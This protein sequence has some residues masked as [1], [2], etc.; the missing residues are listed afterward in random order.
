MEIQ[1]AVFSIGALKFPGPDGF[2]AL[3]YHKYWRIIGRD[4]ITAIRSFFEGKPKM[5]FKSWDSIRAPRDCRGLSI[6]KMYD[7]NKVLLAKQTW[8]IHSLRAKPHISLLK[9]KYLK[10][11]PLHSHI[12]PSRCSYFWRDQ[13]YFVLGAFSLD[14]H[15]PTVG[16]VEAA[17]C[18]IR[19][20]QSLHINSL[21]LRGD[22]KEVIDCL[23]SPFHTLPP[24][25]KALFE[26]L[27]ADLSFFTS[28]TAVYINRAENFIAHKLAQWASFCNL[29]GQSSS[30]QS[31]LQYLIEKKRCR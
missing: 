19:C 27:A 2:S 6:R 10:H 12:P 7:H 17:H 28:W 16:E 24:G 26:E 5:H 9:A 3:F 23:N 18:A 11:Q 25:S 14:N 8:M 20:A 13:M 1:K 30:P 22:S 15:D 29:V 31:P 4:T 21:Y